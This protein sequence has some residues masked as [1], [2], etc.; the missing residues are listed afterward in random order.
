MQSTRDSEKEEFGPQK[1]LEVSSIGSG[2]NVRSKMIGS[3]LANLL[4]SLSTRWDKE[5]QK[6]CDHDTNTIPLHKDFMNPN[7]TLC[8]IE[9]KSGG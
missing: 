1:A 5:K 2:N 8:K 4:L 3:K 9:V 6:V 7:A